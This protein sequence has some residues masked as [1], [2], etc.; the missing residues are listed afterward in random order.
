MYI[1]V[2]YIIST[3]PG[4]RVYP[5]TSKSKVVL[6]LAR[7]RQAFGSWL[8][9]SGTP[10]KVNPAGMEDVTVEIRRLLHIV[11]GKTSLRGDETLT[12]DYSPADDPLALR[13]KRICS[14]N[15]Q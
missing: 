10:G 12:D 4:S 3:M 7:H 9:L 15:P 5:F 6:F 13:V 14:K 2:T 8:V 11:I 1:T